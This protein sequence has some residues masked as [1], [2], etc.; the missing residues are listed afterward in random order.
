MLAA[1]DKHATRRVVGKTATARGLT[2]PGKNRAATETVDP[3][4]RIAFGKRLVLH[5]LGMGAY[6]CRQE[7]LLGWAR[8]CRLERVALGAKNNE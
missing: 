5:A 1:R 7:R 3:A 6:V 8:L 2:Q 4:P